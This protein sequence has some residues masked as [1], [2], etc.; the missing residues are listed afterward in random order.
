MFVIRPSTPIIH[1]FS[2]FLCCCFS[3]VARSQIKQRCLI[4]SNSR[5]CFPKPEWGL[6]Q[7]PPLPAL[8]PLLWALERRYFV[9]SGWG[10][11]LVPDTWP[12]VSS[13]HPFI[14][15]AMAS[16]HSSMPVVRFV[17]GKQTV[18]AK[19]APRCCEPC[20]AT[21]LLSAGELEPSHLAWL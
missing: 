14:Q 11:G 12:A 13:S 21:G 6:G 9:R 15:H 1:I 2:S 3:L 4:S 10:F 17:Q 19:E 18:R 7:W 16:G 5:F 8:N 20:Q